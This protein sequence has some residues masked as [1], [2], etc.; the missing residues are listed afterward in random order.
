M[1]DRLNA[2][3]LERHQLVYF[4]RCPFPLPE[5]DDRR[6]LMEQQV[7]GPSHKNI[8][9]NPVTGDLT[10]A[11]L[12]TPAERQRLAGLLQEFSRSARCWLSE[13]LPEYASADVDRVSL[14]PEEEAIRPLRWTA[15]N[16]LLHIDTFPTRPAQGRR[17][18]RVFVNLHLDE[19]RVWM[20]SETFPEL[21]NRYGNALRV[22]RWEES[23]W[24]RPVSRW[25]R[26]IHADL[27]ERSEYDAWM[28]RLHHTMKLDDVLQEKASRRFYH[29]PPGAAWILFA[30]GLAHAVLRG[31]C[32]LEHSFFVP[33][34]L[35]R[36]PEEAPLSRLIAFGQQRTS[37]RR[38]A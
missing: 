8:S 17:L 19:P 4:P 29:F 36:L 3:T 28:L 21:L 12:R 20:T 27:Y 5:G 24:L 18:L 10:A 2:E 7:G 31:R 26:L 35:W 37:V 33:A 11:R 25:R 6:F 38:A 14:R 15:R 23:R 16:D 34:N 9:W 32:A 30:D 22:P 1:S 13:V